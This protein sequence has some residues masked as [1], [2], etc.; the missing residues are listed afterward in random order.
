M[1]VKVYSLESG[2]E[3]NNE[4]ELADDVFNIH[5][6]NS[7]MSMYFSR[8]KKAGYIRTN[9]T[10]NVSEISGSTKKPYKQKHTGNARQGST[11]SAQMRG[12]GIA[13]GP[14]GVNA[15]IKVPKNEAVLAKS[16]LFSKSLKDGTL[17]VI[18]K[19]KFLSLKT[20]EAKN[21]L[22][23]F[24]DNNIIIINNGNVDSNS[25]LAVRNLYGT[26]FVSNDMVTARDLFYANA[27]LID[28]ESANKFSRVLS[29]SD[30]D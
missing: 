12:G 24:A 22:S 6:D 27:I 10:K 8:M 7:F 25:L 2:N 9:K 4:V 3:I 19:A 23:K 26:K 13:F 30:C 5:Y 17:Y 20:K 15:N 29:V 16:M 1:K 18:E 14:R 21:V 11:R 28:I